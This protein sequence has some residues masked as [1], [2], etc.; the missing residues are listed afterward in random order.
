M[1]DYEIAITIRQITSGIAQLIVL[2]PIF[3]VIANA[4]VDMSGVE[5]NPISSLSAALSVLLQY[6]GSLFPDFCQSRL[7]SVV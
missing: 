2:V 1:V 5:G 3:C 6:C 4:T 7:F